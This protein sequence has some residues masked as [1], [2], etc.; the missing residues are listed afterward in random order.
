MYFSLFWWFQWLRQFGS[1]KFSCQQLLVFFP[2]SSGGFGIQYWLQSGFIYPLVWGNTQIGK[3]FPIFRF[4]VPFSCHRLSQNRFIS[5][6]WW[7]CSLST[8]KT[9]AKNSKPWKCMSFGVFSHT[10]HLPTRVLTEYWVPV[11]PE[12]LGKKTKS[13]WHLRQQ[14]HQSS[15]DR[16]LHRLSD[17]GFSRN[18]SK[19]D[20]P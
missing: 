14:S 12:V 19:F 6:F 11:R 20:R 17:L 2:R 7:S 8:S 9:R 15:M 18:S 5:R 1:P 16:L 3:I 13:C 10:N 4:V